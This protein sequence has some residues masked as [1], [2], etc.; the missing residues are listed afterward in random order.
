MLAP[1]RC[2]RRRDI[3]E[4]HARNRHDDVASLTTEQHE[5]DERVQSAARRMRKAYC[6][7]SV[8]LGQLTNGRACP[9]GNRSRSPELNERVIALSKQKTALIVRSISDRHGTGPRVTVGPPM[10]GW[11]T[12]KGRSRFPN[13]PVTVPSLPRVCLQIS[14]LHPTK[15]QCCA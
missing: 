6:R 4:R 3:D 7:L 9:I 5:I 12:I 2:A 15:N 11:I 1:N 8:C 13:V 10:G 14:V